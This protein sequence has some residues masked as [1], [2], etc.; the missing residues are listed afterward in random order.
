MT[1]EQDKHGCAGPE[2]QAAVPAAAVPSGLSGA[3]AVP[4]SG[5]SCSR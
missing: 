5:A 1:A 3:E 4:A 2:A